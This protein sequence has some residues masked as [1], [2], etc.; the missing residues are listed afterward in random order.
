VLV[1][2]KE[3]KRNKLGICYLSTDFNARETTAFLNTLSEKLFQFLKESL[4]NM[5]VFVHSCNG[6]KLQSE[7]PDSCSCNTVN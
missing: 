7:F 3:L 6:L 5:M 4:E 2:A 1:E